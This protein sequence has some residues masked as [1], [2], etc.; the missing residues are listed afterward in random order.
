MEESFQPKRGKLLSFKY[1]FV[2]LKDAVKEE[3]HL[4]FHLSFAL[5]VI[6]AGFYF[7]ITRE[8]WA[9]VFVMIGLVL[10]AE[11]T[12]TATEAI[13]D[14]FTISQHPKAKFAKDIAAGAVLILA[15]T[16]VIVG[17]IIFLPYFAAWLT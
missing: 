13:V 11:L 6:A 4:K 3:P 2:G 9:L 8:D 16:S 12:N 7:N 14:S 15:I 10:T 17:L 1:A 5:L